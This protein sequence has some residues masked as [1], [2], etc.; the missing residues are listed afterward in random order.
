[1]SRRPR[2]IKRR[3]RRFNLSRVKI[4]ASEKLPKY[5]VAVSFLARDEP[6]ATALAGR[7][8]GGLKVFFFPRNQEE[9]AGTEGLESMR[10][11]FLSES[12]VNVVLYR[13]M[14]GQT[15]WTRVEETAI[16][17]SCLDRGW[18]SL[19]F[20]VLDKNDKLPIWLPNTHVR[21]NLEDY[22]TEQAVGAIKARVQEVGGALR[23]SA[24][25][26]WRR[27]NPPHKSIAAI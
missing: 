3:T 27:R 18:S 8:T 14:W 1:M 11:P 4:G 19:F 2:R 20:I 10:T 7:L 24:S 25:P 15:P 16:K 17:D 13:E 12:R 23:S 6:T 26:A 9:L 21:Y 22:G 5:D